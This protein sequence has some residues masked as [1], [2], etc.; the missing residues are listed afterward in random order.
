VNTSVSIFTTSARHLVL[1]EQGRV[2]LQGGRQV[3]D[4]ATCR[5]GDL[6]DSVRPAEQPRP[7]HLVDLA[8]VPVI[9]Q[10]RNCDVGDVPRRR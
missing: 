8:H 4:P 7:G 9:C 10:R 1:G 6:G 3:A 5:L 2:L